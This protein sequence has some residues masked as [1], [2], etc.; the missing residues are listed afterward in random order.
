MVN[1]MTVTS[2]NIHTQHIL[3]Y[4]NVYKIRVA[5]VNGEAKT[6]Q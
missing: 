4:D 2:F 6:L 5:F 1:L 3:T